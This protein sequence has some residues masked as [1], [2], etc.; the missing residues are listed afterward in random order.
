MEQKEIIIKIQNDKVLFNPQLSINIEQTS[1]PNGYLKFRTNEDI[2]WKVEILEYEAKN[3]CLKV[4]ILDYKATDKTSFTKQTTKKEIEKLVFIGKYDWAELF[5]LLV[6]YTKNK[7]IGQLYNID[8]YDIP[9]TENQQIISQPIEPIITKITEEFWMNFN[10]AQFMLGYITFKKFNKKIGENINFKITNDHILAE[11]DNIK[12]WFSKKL[13]SKKFHVN[14]KITLSGNN[15]KETY[16]TSKE[17][18]L[19]T[20]ALIDSIKYSRT[21]ALT[22]K[23]KDNN[24]DKSLFTAK[25]IFSQIDTDHIEGNVFKQSEL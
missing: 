6:S 24:L 19:I 12:Y 18:D 5:P 16:A 21:I 3:K 15:I 22:K 10:N 4:K 2:Y 23:P 25:D 1:I 8:A 17:I 14:A 7:F 9:K 11:F 20:S 13:K